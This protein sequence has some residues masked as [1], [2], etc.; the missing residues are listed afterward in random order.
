MKGLR[1]SINGLLQGRITRR[2]LL[3]AALPAAGASLAFAGEKSGDQGCFRLGGSWIAVE[4]GTGLTMNEVFIPLDPAGKTAAVRVMPLF[5]FPDVLSMLHADTLS[6]AVGHAEMT[7]RDTAK[8][9]IIEY[10]QAGN[11]PTAVKAIFLVSCQFRF[12]DADTM[13]SSYTQW[14]YPPSADYLPHGDALFPPYSS[15]T[16]TNKRVPLL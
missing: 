5:V 16:V 14:I 3:A 12:I 9:T 6:D 11:P 2:R 8:A 7:G 15:Q 1:P 13:L 10:A 4:E